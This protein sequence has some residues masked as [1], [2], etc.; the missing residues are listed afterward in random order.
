MSKGEKVWKNKTLIV[1]GLVSFFADLASDMLYPITPL[2][3]TN[4]LGA[5]FT[6]VGLIEGVAD[7]VSSLLKSYSGF[8]S[9][10]F[11]RRKPFIV[12]GYLLAAIAKPLTGLATNWSHVLA[13]RS[14]DR[15]GKG[16]RTS[17]RDALLADAFTDENLGAAFGWHRGADTLGATLGPLIALFLLKSHFVELRS[18]YF[19]ALIPGI[20]SVIAALFIREEKKK[21]SHASEKFHFKI[22]PKSFYVFALAWTLFTL[23]NSSD[24]FLLL[25]AKHQGFGIETMILLYC[26]YNLVSALTSPFFGALSDKINKKIILVISLFTFCLSYFLI[27]KA[28]QQWHYYAV[29]SL[30]GLFL[31]MSEGVVKAYATILI[32]KNNR[33]TGLGIL[34]MLTSFATIFASLIAGVLW[35]KVS[36]DAPFYFSTVTGLIGMLIVT[37]L[38]KGSRLKTP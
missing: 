35:D 26:F 28:T 6:S 17:P 7:G 22:L 24:V 15:V 29:L 19:W 38:P 32:G 3:L 8:F 11:S 10:K 5:S 1:L 4:I 34:G 23:S 2:F 27:T 9:D 16:V 14:L 37:F 12:F 30:Y 33:G 31:A 20:L 13:A 36:P 21:K 18:F 25:R